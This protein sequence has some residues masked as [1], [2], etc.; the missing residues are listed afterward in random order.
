MTDGE[1]IPKYKGMKRITFHPFSFI[2]RMDKIC[3]LLNF[4]H[5]VTVFSDENQE[6]ISDV[7]ATGK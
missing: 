2:N 6:Q 1:M 4:L 3:R 5:F 7:A